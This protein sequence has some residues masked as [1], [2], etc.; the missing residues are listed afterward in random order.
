MKNEEKK[1]E[2]VT[3]ELDELTDEQLETILGG[4]VIGGQTYQ[5]VF[6]A[7]VL[8]LDALSQTAYHGGSAMAGVAITVGTVLGSSHTGD[9]VYTAN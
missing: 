9:T 3:T 8:T 6:P 7:S 5:P 1:K 2:A 4:F